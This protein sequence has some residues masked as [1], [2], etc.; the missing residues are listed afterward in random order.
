MRWRAHRRLSQTWMQSKRWVF[1]RFSATIFVKT[2]WPDTIPASLPQ[3]CSN[4]PFR[5]PRQSHRHSRRKITFHLLTRLFA[6]LLQAVEARSMKISIMKITAFC[7]CVLFACCSPA[8]VQAQDGV[9]TGH[10]VIVQDID[11]SVKP[12]DNF[13]E[14]SNGE[15]LKR[16]E[17]PPDRGSLRGSSWL[18]HVATT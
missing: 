10:G 12:G 8:F 7:S 5:H 16:T 2:A 4:W 6:E 11:R 17:I 13:F 9:T 14:H 1:V 3:I 18:S 15:W